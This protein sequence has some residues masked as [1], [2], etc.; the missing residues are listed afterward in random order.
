MKVSELFMPI[1]AATVI[2]LTGE[3]RQLTVSKD[4]SKAGLHFYMQH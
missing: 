3:E 4:R 1:E 2:I